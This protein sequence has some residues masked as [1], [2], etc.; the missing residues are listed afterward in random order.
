VAGVAAAVAALAGALLVG[1]S[2]RAS[3]RDLVLGRLGNTDT[4]ITASGYFRERLAEVFPGAAPVIALQGMVTHQE[5]GRRGSS[6]LVYGVDERF[7]RFHGR[8]ASLTDRQVLLSEALVRELGGK[9]GDGILVRMENPSAIP[10]E[11]IHGRRDQLGRTIRLS[12]AGGDPGEFAL[13][14]QQGE[15]RA[16]FVSLRRLQKELGQAGRVNTLLLAS[17]AGAEQT[18]RKAFE[19][20]DLGLRLRLL[21][22][23]NCIS[24]ESD[25]LLLADAVAERARAAAAKAGLRTQGI[26]TYL[27]NTIRLGDR[28]VPY[29]LVSAI[30]E[31]RKEPS[32][33]TTSAPA[34]LVLN[35][36]AARDL[37]AKAGDSVSL[38]YYLWGGDGR[39]STSR[40]QF[41]LK[42]VVPIQG[43]AA[44]RDLA[45]HFPGITD[46]PNLDNWDPPFPLDLKRIRPKDEDYW[47]RYRT[48][49]KA[50][51]LLEKGQELWGSRFGR[52]TSLRVTP[53]ELDRYRAALREAL[54]P[55]QA[56]LAILPVRQQSLEASQGSTDFG[57]YF[58]Y[59]SF[60]L[61][62]A[63]LLLAGLFFRLGV[64]Q[65]LREI[66]LLRSLGFG[67]EILRNLF[68]SEGLVLATAGS[69]L[70]L[71]AAWGYSGLILHGLRTWWVGAV[72]TQ[73][74]RLH[75]SV[76]PLAAG[77]AGGVAIALLCVA[78]TL[79]G[80]RRS[81]PR[82][83]LSGAALDP[84]LRSSRW[85]RIAA[86][87]APVLALALLV[88]PIPQAGAFFGAGTLLLIAAL[89]YQ[90]TWLA[91]RRGRVLSTVLQLGFRN[92]AH[93]PG[94]SLLSISLIASAIFL[95]VAIDA[96]RRP[97][98]PSWQDKNSGA[99]GYPLLAESLIP[100]VNLA[101]IEGVKF[102]PFRLRPGDDASCLNLYQPQNPR[103]LG[104]PS[105]FLRE[106]GFGFQNWTLL[107]QDLPG[108]VVPAIADANSIT[109]VLHKRV[110]DDVM[111]GGHRLRLVGALSHSL[112]Q[113][114]L[115]I[116]E[117]HFLRL[118]PHEP[119]Y[120]FFLL[121][122]ADAGKL[123][124]ALADYGFDALPTSDRLASFD[125]VENTYLSTF[126]ALGG[127]GL[128]LGTV[129]LAAVLL[130]NVLE[131]RR[132]LALLEAVGYRPRDL[133]WMV[134]A[135]NTFLVAS[136]VGIGT[137]CALVAIAPAF[138]SRGGQLSVASMAVL[139]AGV[140]ITGMAASLAAV[141]AVVRAPL[142]AVLRAE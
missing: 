33:Y 16:A 34:T 85:P 125:R 14:P 84:D 19:L 117:K 54:D 103:V 15:V 25:S 50:F 6:V 127:L 131:R 99:G 2:V 106:A 89:C 90:W 44:D 101:E 70:G 75:P 37:S 116:A 108:G 123:E 97:E 102:V 51:I 122:T 93:R 29:S 35:D 105:A 61:V 137:L 83:L 140:V 42:G 86:I 120:R 133:A 7:W 71:A 4:V 3:L 65:R 128:L 129:G 79:R 76:V 58:L 9:P 126:Q 92:A 64:E 39:L 10:A 52:L 46:S 87:G 118:F 74:L 17:G 109:Y 107:E 138:V 121:E 113:G 28:E 12:L 94:R 55:L 77:G 88:A 20:E 73:A 136:G 115:L 45:P 132:E 110:G 112:F 78:W 80:L 66:G 62:A 32:A 100:I 91:A 104:V 69:L 95:L 40:A 36:W 31:E 134:V 27:A 60:F 53:P 43:A 111:V 63:A 96:F 142:L 130:R 47:D 23:R 141:R 38:E 56:G 41:V 57:E 49:P 26:F 81:S 8:Q 72:G 114:E 18:L 13:R 68:L 22:E 119:G 21:P 59:F 24:V 139:L 11:T 135:E 82:S 124:E 30:E 48:T 1:H 5:S 98:R 67:P